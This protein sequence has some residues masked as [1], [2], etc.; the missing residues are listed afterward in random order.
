MGLFDRLFRRSKPA[1]PEP[2][3]QPGGSTMPSH[4]EWE[5]MSS[6]DR[7]AWLAGELE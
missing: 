3:A 6:T 1:E 4:A 5:D 2:A 7:I